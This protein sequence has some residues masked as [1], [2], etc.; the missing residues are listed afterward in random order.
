LILEEI[1]GPA[2]PLAA[3]TLSEALLVEVLRSTPVAP[4]GGRDP[5]IRRAIELIEA[6]YAEALGIDEL[7]R[8]AGMSRFH[9][10]RQFR[11]QTGQSPYRFLLA[12]R[13]RRA[14]AL[15]AGGRAS[16]TE[17]ALEVGFTDLGRFAAAFRRELGCAPSAYARRAA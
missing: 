1:A 9:F 15:L 13:V 3:E 5:R 17:A 14:A 8:E 10:S 12:T 7:S 16:V 2:L 4:G 6:R 11:A